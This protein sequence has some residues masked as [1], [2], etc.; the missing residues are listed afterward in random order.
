MKQESETDEVAT[1]V[2][3]CIGVGVGVVVVESIGEAEYVMF[4]FY[5]TRHGERKEEGQIL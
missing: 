2:I 3:I 4:V 1:G 5:Q